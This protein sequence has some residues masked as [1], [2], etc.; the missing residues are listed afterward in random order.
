VFRQALSL[1]GSPEEIDRDFEQQ[2]LQLI[3]KLYQPPNVD[4]GK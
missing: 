2:Y 3:M 1:P 4:A